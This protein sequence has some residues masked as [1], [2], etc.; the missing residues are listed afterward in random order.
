MNVQKLSVVQIRLYPQDTLPTS[1]I[2]S[3][4]GHQAIQDEFQ[5]QESGIPL[6]LEGM[7]M[8]QSV[9]PFRDGEF[10]DDDG[11]RVTV[12]GLEIQGRRIVTRVDG[13]STQA[14]NFFRKF[15]RALISVDDAAEALSNVIYQAE[16]TSCLV[17]L[18]LDIAQAFRPKV[19]RF[20][21]QN[22]AQAA[23]EP[24]IRADARPAAFAVSI[25]YD[26][27]D[28]IITDHGLTLNPKQF[29]VEPRVNTPRSESIYVTK[30]PYRT[31][32][33][34]SLLDEFEGLFQK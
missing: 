32:I 20:I 5:F 22:L 17:R 11:Q 29:T 34:L 23:S 6:I 4:R 8:V 14:D 33:H 12:T 16:E 26:V 13:T 25:T 30:S 19:A 31:D 9:I 28:P 15:I 1:L 18:D 3:P 10:E 2:A 27:R 24:M 7:P 21:R